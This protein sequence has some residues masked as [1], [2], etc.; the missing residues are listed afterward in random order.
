MGMFDNIKGFSFGKPINEKKVEPI[1]VGANLDKIRERISEEIGGKEDEVVIDSILDDISHEMI[2]MADTDPNV[3]EV[4]SLFMDPQK[5]KSFTDYSN[6]KQKKID[7]IFTGEVKDLRLFSKSYQQKKN[8]QAR[9]KS[10]TRRL[11]LELD[12][13]RKLIQIYQVN[14]HDLDVNETDV[15]I[16]ALKRRG[17]V[18][19]YKTPDGEISVK[20]GKIGG[21]DEDI[22]EEYFQLVSQ[23]GSKRAWAIPKSDPSG[24]LKKEDTKEEIKLDPT[25]EA[26]I[27]KLVSDELSKDVK[28]ITSKEED[29]EKISR[30]YVETIR[31]IV[32]E[33]KEKAKSDDDN[34][35]DINQMDTI[36]KDSGFYVFNIYINQ[37]DDQTTVEDVVEEIKEEEESKKSEDTRKHREFIR[38]IMSM[39]ENAL[40]PETAEGGNITKEGGFYKTFIEIHNNYKEEL[41]D[42]VYRLAIELNVK[43]DDFKTENPDVQYQ[44]SYLDA[45]RGFLD[46]MVERHIEPTAKRASNNYKRDISSLYLEKKAYIKNKNMSRKINMGD[47]AGVS[48]KPNINV[49]LY[50][51]VKIPIT[52]KDLVENSV[53]NKLKNAVSTFTSMFT[54]GYI[55]NHVDQGAASAAA[56]RNQAILQNINNLAKGIAKIAG[57]EK[58]GRKVG[59]GFKHAANVLGMEMKDKK[60]I[61]ENKVEN[62][63]EDMLVDMS[64]PSSPG[65]S[66]QQPGQLPGNNMDTFSLLGPGKKKS[67]GKTKKKGK[68][69]SGILSFDDFVKKGKQ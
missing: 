27:R 2:Q 31:K 16:R 52:D 56:N 11:N 1:N 46:R 55:A 43:G 57:G 37:G 30:E 26:F 21:I 65:S 18:F 15:I 14:S 45:I 54:G 51:T 4:F 67:N 19:T 12:R 23:D 7:S 29:L 58:A 22:D 28:K 48:I 17:H 53:L 40:L 8:E 42:L 39:L 64:G 60:D 35:L 59:L 25:T 47:F 10:G 20:V 69:R 13:F 32:E 68:K 36:L 24:Y 41:E 62:L 3:L 9:F 66:L 44:L 33:M 5:M 61:K 6:K 38:H 49:P 63:E 50:K 34:D